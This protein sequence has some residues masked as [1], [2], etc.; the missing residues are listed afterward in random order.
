MALRKW[1][2]YLLM[3][4]IIFMYNIITRLFKIVYDFKISYIILKIY[5][6]HNIIIIYHK[7]FYQISFQN[8]MY[9]LYNS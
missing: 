4:I 8:A 9:Y 6:T 7:I 3:Y 2:Y 5:R 1:Y